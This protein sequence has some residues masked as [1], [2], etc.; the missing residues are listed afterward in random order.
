[1]LNRVPVRGFDPYTCLLKKEKILVR[2]VAFLKERPFPFLVKSF[3]RGLK[4]EEFTACG[5]LGFE[6]LD[7]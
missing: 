2:R 4:R 3:F 1:M 7:L 6:S 5:F